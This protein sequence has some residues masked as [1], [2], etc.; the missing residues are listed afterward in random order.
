MVGE[1]VDE[2]DLRD[3]VFGIEPHEA[4]MHQALLRQLANARLARIRPRRVARCAAVGPS[5]GAKRAPGA[6]GTAAFALRSGPEA[7]RCLG[8]SRAAMY[9]R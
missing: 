2:I 5:P 7:A 1:T 4:V 3:D 8:R 9:K 6:R